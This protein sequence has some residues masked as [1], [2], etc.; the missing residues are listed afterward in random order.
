MKNTRHEKIMKYVLFVKL[1]QHNLTIVIVHTLLVWNL[2]CITSRPEALDVHE[3][4]RSDFEKK[5]HF[6]PEKAQFART[7][8]TVK[9]RVL[10]CV[11]N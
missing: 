4:T 5:N 9:S 6:K 3:V 7:P 10:T 1:C 8:Y 11:T 2:V